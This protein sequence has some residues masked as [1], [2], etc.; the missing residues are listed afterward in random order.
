MG[1]Q[2]LVFDWSIKSLWPMAGQGNRGGTFRIPKKEMQRQ[3]EERGSPFRR[4]RRQ[5]CIGKRCLRE[6]IGDV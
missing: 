5:T 3:G 6:G 4:G 1:I 2:Q